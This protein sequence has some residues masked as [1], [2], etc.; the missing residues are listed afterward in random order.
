L[1]EVFVLDKVLDF[2]KSRRCVIIFQLMFKN[3]KLVAEVV[4]RNDVA[5]DVVLHKRDIPLGIWWG[6][7]QDV[8]KVRH[9]IKREKAEKPIGDEI[10]FVSAIVGKS[11][12]EGRHLF[13]EVDFRGRFP[14][15]GETR[16]PDFERVAVQLDARNRLAADVAHVILATVVYG[17]LQQQAVGKYVAQP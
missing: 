10:E 2:F 8:F 5:I 15:S 14:C 11:A 13:T 6:L 1:G 12:P 9:R 17:T 3:K 4:Y 7:Q 16:I